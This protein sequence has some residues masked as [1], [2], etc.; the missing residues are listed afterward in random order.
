MRYAF[1][2]RHELMHRVRLLC[3]VM[4][5]HPSGYYAWRQQPH[6]ARATDDQRLLGLLKQA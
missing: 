2:Q 3:K 6:S 5:V 1:I 4:A